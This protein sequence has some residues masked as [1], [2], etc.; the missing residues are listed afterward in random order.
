MGISTGFWRLPD[1]VEEEE[2]ISLVVETWDYFQKRKCLKT[3]HIWL[4]Q[5][6]K[7]GC[8]QVVVAAFHRQLGMVMRRA[9]LGEFVA[10]MKSEVVE[11]GRFRG[12]FFMCLEVLP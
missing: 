11:K 6:G 7:C 5:I 3:D 8:M 10:I 12:L 4:W 2:T 1:V 9:V